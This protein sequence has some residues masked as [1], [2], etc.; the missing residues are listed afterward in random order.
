MIKLNQWSQETNGLLQAATPNK[1]L[2]I[3][4]SVSPQTVTEVA[5][6]AKQYGVQVIDAPMSGGEGGAKDGTL[7]FMV[8]S[9]DKEA[10]ERS[11]PILE[12]IGQHVFYIGNTGAG[13]VVKL[14]NNLM[15]WCNNLI[16]IEAVKLVTGYGIEEDKLI[17]VARV[18]TGNSY[19]VENWDFGGKVMQTHTLAGTKDVYKFLTKD[20][21]L[22]V[23]SASAVDVSLPI[24]ELC[25]QVSEEM[26]EERDNINR[27]NGRIYNKL[28]EEKRIGKRELN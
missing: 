4:S 9:D 12:S 2:I 27:A 16:A 17:E 8:G 7:T 1:L 14:A 13:E 28:I 20:I 22:A 19:L 10:F 26:L 5:N 6:K 24:T 15:T 11:R 18:S 21:I 25:T 23:Q 3:N